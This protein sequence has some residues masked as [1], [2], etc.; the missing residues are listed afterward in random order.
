MP[1]LMKAGWDPPVDQPWTFFFVDQFIVL[2]QMASVHTQ[3]DGL[4]VQA[5]ELDLLRRRRCSQFSFTPCVGTWLRVRPQPDPHFDL[6]TAAKLPSYSQDTSD[7]VTIWHE[8]PAI[9]PSGIAPAT[10]TALNPEEVVRD[11]DRRLFAFP[12]PEDA[13]SM[14]CELENRRRQTDL[15]VLFWDCSNV[16]LKWS[17]VRSR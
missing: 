11:T 14:H 1:G 15:P 3:L 8:R 12:N 13:S 6:Q 10:S 9:F 17:S 7:G 16:P 5:L 2:H 4:E